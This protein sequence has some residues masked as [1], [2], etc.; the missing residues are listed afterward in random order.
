[1]TTKTETLHAGAFLISYE[2]DGHYC[3]EQATVASGQTL[4]AG[5]AV[6][7]SGG[8]LV[9]WDGA[10]ASVLV[11]L[12]LYPVD[13]SGGDTKGTYLARGTAEVRGADLTYPASTYALLVADLKALSPPI[14]VR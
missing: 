6:M 7:L 2:D 1:M 9:T 13:A 5:E 10:T 8:K 3:F 14:I 12:M 11:G 4:D